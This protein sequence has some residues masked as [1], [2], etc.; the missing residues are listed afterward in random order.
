MCVTGGDTHRPGQ[1]SPETCT[2]RQAG[3]R[4]A[5]RRRSSGPA[6][7]RKADLRTGKRQAAGRQ[8]AQSL[9]G[10]RRQR[11]T[12][13]PVR[14]RADL[15]TAAPGPPALPPPLIRECN[16]RQ[17]RD[18]QSRAESEV[19]RRVRGRDGVC[20]QRHGLGLSPPQHARPPFASS[21]PPSYQS[22]VPQKQQWPQQGAIRTPV[23]KKKAATGRYTPPQA[24]IR[25]RL[26]TPAPHIPVADPPRC[27]GPPRPA[28]VRRAVA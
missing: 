7:R 27:L 24:A 18:R 20:N 25:M 28:P 12:A 4:Q 1:P 16:Q 2:H 26:P 8:A 6:D 21:P 3:R 17:K 14:R 9:S 11:D 23:R 5:G 22:A 19:E 13:D 10:L 15:L